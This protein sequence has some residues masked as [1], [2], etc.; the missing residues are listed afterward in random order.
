MDIVSM[1]NHLNLDL[2]MISISGLSYQFTKHW[3]VRIRSKIATL[4]MKI[5]KEVT[6]FGD[7]IWHQIKQ[8]ISLI[9]TL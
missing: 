6:A 9:C 7:M 4:I 5:T 8:P 1:E 2:E 3:Q